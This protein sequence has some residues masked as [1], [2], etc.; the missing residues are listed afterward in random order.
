MAGDRGRDLTFSILSDTD[1][2]Q[3]AEPA[4]QLEQL[5]DAA[6]KAG[7]DLD[8]L[9]GTAAARDLDKLGQAADDAGR[10]LEK[11]DTRRSATE[12][13]QLGDQS[14][15]TARKMD[16]AFDTIAR[17]SQTSARKLDAN[18][19][20]MKLDLDDVGDE[21]ADTAREMGASFDGSSDSIIDAFQEFGSLAGASLGPIG[22][23]AGAA[24]ATGVGLIRAEQEKL[25]VMA[26]E[27]VD[28]MLEAGGK[29][30]DEVIDARIRTMAAE[31]PGDL[32]KQKR[33]VDELGLSW[34][35]YIR[36]KAG[37]G[38]AAERSI[39]AMAELNTKITEQASAAGSASGAMYAQQTQLGQL[40]G[41]LTT[42]ADAYKIAQDAIAAADGATLRSTDSM[43]DAKGQW[44][45]LQEAMRDPI[46]GEVILRKPSKGQL[47][48]V[49]Q[50]LNDGIGPIIV[51]VIARPK[52]TALF[53]PGDRARP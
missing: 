48:S 6:A 41:D 13:E 25:K 51:D 22:V 31:D 46:T 7:T 28:E 3:L 52:N 14:H 43:A 27:M 1:K 45:E 50:D 20:K 36:A 8:K 12:L 40:A 16:T 21:A 15:D 35:D 34:R 53:Y 18:T 44:G 29:L 10:D 19:D 49:R 47:A 38:E 30:T 42:T 23:A 24:A 39:Q 9:D 17:A 32:A 5:G 4:R 2:L 26:S 11:L 37:D 33:I